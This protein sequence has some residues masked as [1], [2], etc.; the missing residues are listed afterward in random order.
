MSCAPITYV[1]SNK[2]IVPTQRLMQ[3]TTI[4]TIVTKL[5]YK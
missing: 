4:N 2:Y 5:G 3:Y 1:V